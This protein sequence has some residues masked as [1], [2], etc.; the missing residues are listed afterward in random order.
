VVAAQAA[1]GVVLVVLIMVV[2][3]TQ[4]VLLEGENPVNAVLPEVLA[5]WLAIAVY[6]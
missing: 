2:Q 1:A 4:A 3:T 5:R 6:L